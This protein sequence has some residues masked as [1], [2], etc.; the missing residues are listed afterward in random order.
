MIHDP[1]H[2]IEQALR[3]LAFQSQRLSNM[4]ANFSRYTA[5]DV[6]RR[7]LSQEGSPVE[8]RRGERRD[9]QRATSGRRAL[10]DRR[11]P[12]EERIETWHSQLQQILEESMNM[13]GLRRG[14]L[15]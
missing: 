13:A 6:N 15:T 1:N 9:P 7:D 12:P 2:P 3:D 10:D 5:P 11:L 14:F 8:R 4:I